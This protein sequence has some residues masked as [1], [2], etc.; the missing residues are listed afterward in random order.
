MC[1]KV[2]YKALYEFGSI[3]RVIKAF[4]VSS[5]VLILVT[6][7]RTILEIFWMAVKANL[8]VFGLSIKDALPRVEVG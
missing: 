6:V 8:S 2:T 4:F 1:F 7:D 3:V 5:V